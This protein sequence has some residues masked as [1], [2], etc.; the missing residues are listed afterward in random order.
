MPTNDFENDFEKLRL[1]TNAASD[2]CGDGS[3]D[4]LAIETSI[5]S[6]ILCLRAPQVW[7]HL[8]CGRRL[9]IPRT[10]IYFSR[11]YAKVYEIRVLSKYNWRLSSGD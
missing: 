3:V 9:Q 10:D 6:G 1:P 2:W 5:K 11:V 7:S 4:Y 8:I